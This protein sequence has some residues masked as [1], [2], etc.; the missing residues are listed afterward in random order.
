MSARLTT[1]RANARLRRERWK[2]RSSPKPRRG[3]VDKGGDHGYT[4]VNFL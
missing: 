4:L 2:R 3:I 1:P